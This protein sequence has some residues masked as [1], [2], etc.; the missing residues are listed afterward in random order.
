MVAVALDGRGARGTVNVVAFN[1]IGSV[2]QRYL[3]Y[4]VLAGTNDKAVARGFDDCS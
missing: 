3:S 4:R 1:V 2:F